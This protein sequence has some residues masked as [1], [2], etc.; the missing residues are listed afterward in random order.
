M[1]YLVISD[2]SGE[3]S[4]FPDLSNMKNMQ[5]L[6]LRSCN[7]TGSIPEYISNMTSLQV[8][9]L[10]FNRLKGSIP[11]LDNL[12]GLA[13]IYLTSNWLTGLPEWI[14]N[15]DSRYIVD[16]SYNNFSRDSVPTTCRE[17]FNVFKSFSR[18]NNPILSNCLYPCSKEQYSL[19]INCGGKPITIGG[20]KYEGDEA[21]GGGAK[22]FQDTVNWGFSSTGD[23]GL[24]NFDHAYI[25]N[26]IS[27]LKMNN[28][29]LY[30]TARL[31]FLSLT[32][33]ARC[34]ANGNY[35]VKLH[36]A[37]IV[38]RDNRSY[39]GVGSRFF[40]VYIQDKLV[41]KDFNIE[42]EAQGIDKEVI[43]VFK[44]V[45]SVSTLEIRFYWAGK[46]TMN[47]P[48]RGTYGS[49]ISAIS[50]ESGK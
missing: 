38:L 30:R 13:T 1:K 28:S 18:Q 8:L 44:A 20:I 48:K 15:R 17:T 36:F 34:L 9:D 41:L 22:F 23:Y 21:S 46:G 33:Y 4:V 42:K 43:K 3:S 6:M 31:S 27:I 39:Y 5:T 7:M 49:L 25:E 35:T 37:E 12:L 32:Y 10:S 14:T 45:V 19:H 11:N 47:V 26:N 40:D 2:L 16:L 50:V 24:T 29:E